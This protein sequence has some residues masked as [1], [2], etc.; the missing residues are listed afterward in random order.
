MKDIQEPFL[1]LE[2]VFS[3]EFEINNED[4]LPKTLEEIE[5]D[6]Y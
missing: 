2:N 3:E 4:V 6:I 1:C 5:A